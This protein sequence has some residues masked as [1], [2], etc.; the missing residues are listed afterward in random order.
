MKPIKEQALLLSAES[1]P[2]NI[3]GNSGVSHKLRFLVGTEIFPL[4]ATE[5][6]VISFKQK[7]GDEGELTF[8]LTSRKE[9][10]QI[11]FVSFE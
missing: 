7:E 2:Y 9:N 5:N 3:D 8:R 1:T 11:H 6:D 10:P 4:R